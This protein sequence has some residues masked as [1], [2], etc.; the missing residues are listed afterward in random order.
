[1]PPFFRIGD[2]LNT[3]NVGNCLF[4]RRLES[5]KIH[6]KFKMEINLTA[7][8]LHKYLYDPSG[9][10]INFTLLQ[11]WVTG[12]ISQSVWERLQDLKLDDKQKKNV[13]HLKANTSLMSFHGLFW[14]TKN[15]LI[16]WFESCFF[17]AI[18]ELKLFHWMGCKNYQ[19]KRRFLPTTPLT[20]HPHNK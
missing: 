6:G 12:Y 10:E 4:F 9:I 14:S 1:M 8:H 19:Q 3:K 11:W 5:H 20:L 7:G 17:F 2:A 15:T 18:F 13:S 16:N